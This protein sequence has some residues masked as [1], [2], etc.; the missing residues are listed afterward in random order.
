[1]NDSPFSTAFNNEAITV[2]ALTNLQ[3]GL[4]N[5]LQWQ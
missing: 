2:G 5:F 4:E 3:T 1:M